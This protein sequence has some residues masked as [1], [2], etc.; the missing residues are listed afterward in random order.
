MAQIKAHYANVTHEHNDGSE[1]EGDV[2]IDRYEVMDGVPVGVYTCP[3]CE[4][5]V[6]WTDDSDLRDPDPFADRD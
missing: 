6:P 5:D 4:R 1:F 2:E 3:D